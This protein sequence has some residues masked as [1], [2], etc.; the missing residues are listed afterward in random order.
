MTREED[1]IQYLLA[2]R[3]S[4]NSR[5]VVIVLRDNREETMH[6]EPA[7]LIDNTE[8]VEVDPVERFGIILDDRYDDRTSSFGESFPAPRPTTPVSAPVT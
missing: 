2:R 5:V 8:Y 4:S 1:F 3:L 7:V 6:V